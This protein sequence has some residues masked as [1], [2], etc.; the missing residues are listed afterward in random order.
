MRRTASALQK[1]DDVVVIVV[2]DDE[3]TVGNSLFFWETHLTICGEV[4]GG[5]CRRMG[6]ATLGVSSRRSSR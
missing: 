5:V 2:D 3:K 1:V 4:C 6:C